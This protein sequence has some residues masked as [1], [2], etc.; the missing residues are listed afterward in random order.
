MGF[1]SAFKG[2]ILT[3]PTPVVGG[4]IRGA[5]ASRLLGLRVRIPPGHN[6]LS[7]VCIVCSSLY[8]GNHRYRGAL[9]SVVCL[10]VIMKLDSE[11]TLPSRGC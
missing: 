7:L 2:L 10:S 6:R 8:L 4:L 9:P 3:L 1:N 11:K 5:A